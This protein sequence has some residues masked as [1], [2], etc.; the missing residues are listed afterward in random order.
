MPSP[1][2]RV[3]LIHP[4]WDF[5][6]SSVSYDLRAERALIAQQVEGAID[7]EWTDAER[8]ECVLVLQTMATPPAWTLADLPELPVVV[9]AAQRWDRIPDGLDHG[10]ITAEGATVGTP[11]LTSVLV[12]QRRPFELVVGRID[13]PKTRHDV[14]TALRGAAAATRIR[15]ARIAR[16]GKPQD[17][18]ACVDTPS[19]FLAARV[20]VTVVEL[21]PA[22]VLHAYERVPSGRIAAMQR[23]VEEA[24]SLRV[25]ADDLDRSLRAACAIED[26]VAEHDLDAGAMNCHVPEI[27]LG[28]IGI[29]PC[30]GLGRSATNGVPWSCTGDVLTAMALLTSRALG[31]AAQYHELESYD[32]ATDEFVLAS[33]GEHDLNL[34]P[35]VRPELVRNHWFPND[36]GISVCAC[37]TAPAGPATLLAFADVGGDYRLIVAEGQ[38]TGRAFPS[39]GTANGGF[40]FRDGLVSWRRWCEQ[41][42][43]H[44]SAATPGALGSAAAICA[45]FLGIQEAAV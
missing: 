23:E 31:G 25:S 9:W 32:Y 4:Y 11:M 41:G 1:R 16:V 20:G 19:E 42:A 35:D 45:R 8:A 7:V 6:E 30:F 38:F 29:A 28:G 33:S 26:L 12:R 40:R 34:A 10:G 3:T 14:A 21:T 44:H 17:G 37:F 13:D 39:T 24:F 18:Y 27:R 5:W 36:A 43:N 22:D 15:G 2:P